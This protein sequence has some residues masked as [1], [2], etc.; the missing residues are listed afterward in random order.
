MAR[1]KDSRVTDD[2]VRRMVELQ[3]QGKSIS[4]ISRTVKCHRQTV[5]K[6]LAGRGSDILAGEVKKQLLTDVQQKHLDDLTQFA[7]SLRSHLTIPN[8]ATEDR[9][10]VEVLAPLLPKDLPQ[11]LDSAS[12]KARREQRQA[13][14]QNK[15][16][17]ESLRQH[18]GGKGWWQAFE[19]WQQAWATCIEG[20][21]EVK[22]VPEMVEDLLNQQKAN[23][24][25]E[26]EKVTGKEDVLER[27]V[28]VVIWAAW[29]VATA[30]NP[31]EELKLRNFRVAPVAKQRR[32][33]TGG[34]ELRLIF[35]E[36][37]TALAQEVV[38]VC[39]NVLR[40]LYP[41]Y[42]V[43]EILGML[44]RM[45]EKIE[46]IDDALDPFILRPL[47]VSTRCELCPV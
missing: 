16:L 47:L 17:F 30:S 20:L 11:G 3:R 4:F 43:D 42:M 9:D 40:E 45:D 22:N 38:A 33:T 8:L 24:K 13:D 39:N 37:E 19:E 31:E 28:D 35:S 26:V 23:L 32:I 25:E 18:A 34:Y 1:H 44:H 6:Y 10:V 7:I 27:I 15:M 36:P 46:V 21:G 14:R 2:Q 5:E 12:R 41:R 29:Q